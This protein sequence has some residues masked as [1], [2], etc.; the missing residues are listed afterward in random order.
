MNQFALDPKTAV[1]DAL[2][3][4]HRRGQ[5]HHAEA[6]AAAIGMNKREIRA[7][8]SALREEGIAVCGHPKTG[9]FIAANAEEL[10]TTVEFLKSRAMHSLHLASRLTKIPLVDLLGQLKLKT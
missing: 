5:R 6:L 1:L 2:R 9:Y 3:K 10:E 4:P 7:Q 8:V